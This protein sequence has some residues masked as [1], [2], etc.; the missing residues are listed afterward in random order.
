M[1]RYPAKVAPNP[2]VAPNP[3][4]SPSQQPTAQGFVPT[5]PCT[6]GASACG[7][8]NGIEFTSLYRQV[9]AAYTT[10][11]GDVVKRVNCDAG[12]PPNH[13]LVGH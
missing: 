10:K 12:A 3:A 2:E 1:G 8:D 13:V 11:T 4:A 6:M 7:F 5:S 9:G